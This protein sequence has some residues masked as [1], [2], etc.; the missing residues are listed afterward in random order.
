MK[1][2]DGMIRFRK[3]GKTMDVCSEV[4]AS[5]FKNNGWVPMDLTE[6]VIEIGE[7][8]ETESLNQADD[9]AGSVTKSDQESQSV[10]RGR[11]PAARK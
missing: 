3:D 4:Q 8:T 11:K 9:V 1:V 10:K 5:A 7:N 2:R 6:K